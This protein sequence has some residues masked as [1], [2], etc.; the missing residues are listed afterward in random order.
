MKLNK[1]GFAFSTILYGSVALIAAVLY[2][3]L[4]V[5]KNSNDTTYYFGEELVKSLNECVTEEVALENCYSSGANNCNATAYHACL[6]VS[7]NYNYERGTIISEELKMLVVTHDDGLYL[8]PYEE[9][10][11]IYI[12]SSVNNYINYSGK[13]WRILSIEPGGFLKLVDTNMYPS[14]SWDNNGIGIWSNSTLYY[15][16]NTNYLS[17][18]IDNSKLS[19][20]MWYFPE[21]TPEVNG[22]D[23]EDLIEQEKNVEN[24]RIKTSRVGILSLSDYLRATTNT[25]CKTNLFSTNEPN[26][27]NSWLSQYKGWTI[28][29]NSTETDD[30]EAYY[31]GDDAENNKFNKIM[32]DRTNEIHDV[33]PVIYL[34]RNSIYKSGTGTLNN[35]Y[36]LK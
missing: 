1:K 12:G 31:F 29:V 7:D 19:Q 24:D 25:N 33:Y 27:C 22:F 3:I 17:S 11:Y 16:L 32:I 26:N 28:D 36:E 6:G 20:G 5:S 18:I 21:I 23:L 2:I 34:D 13:L 9:N 30:F 35:P 10:R 4:N 14:V 8:D 15:S